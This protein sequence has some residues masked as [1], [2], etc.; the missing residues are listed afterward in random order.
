MSEEIVECKVCKAKTIMYSHLGNS[1]YRLKHY[2][3][4]IKSIKIIDDNNER[5]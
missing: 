1:Y 3:D 4:F 2:N 5:I